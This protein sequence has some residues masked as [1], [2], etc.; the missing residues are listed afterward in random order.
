MNT[1]IIKNKIL[2]DKILKDLAS[3]FENEIYLVGGGVRD[4]ILGKEITD[5][6][7]IVTGM[8]AKDFALKA[9]QIFDGKFIELDEV[10]NIYRVVMKDKINE[11][12]ITN[13]VENSLEKD[14][15]RR[16][17]TINALAVNIKTGEILDLINGLSDIEN[18][19]L[20]GI[21]EENFTDDP[22]RIL[23][24]FRFHSTTGFK[25]SDNLMKIAKKYANLI[26]EPAKERVEYELMKLFD[27]K[28][29]HSALLKMDEAGILEIIFPFVKE[30]KQVPPN[31]HH[32]L[33]LFHHSIETVRQ[34]QLIYENEN[35]FVKKHMNKVDFGGF[36]R[37][38]HLKLA[39]FMH[40]IGKFSTWFI[41]SETGRHRFFKHEDV[42][43]KMCPEI[44]RKLSFSNK[45]INYI[46]LMIKNHM[47]PSMVMSSPELSEKAM[48]RYIRK[49]GDN[50]IDA[51]IIAKADRLS[52]LGPEI[53][54]R[55]VED[56]LNSLTRL[57]D[58]YIKFLDT[59]KPLPKLL[60]GNEVMKLLNISPSPK[61]GKILNA[62]H[63]AQLN[64]D[65]TTKN[66]AVEFVR[67]Y[68]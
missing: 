6:D 24:I 18:G 54:K 42:G 57:C 13:P 64:E 56:N 32:H 15:F 60:D 23:R 62:L 37:L 66:Q 16:D 11:L 58:F 14:I 5:R 61:L 39:G 28:F 47:Y 55:M 34:I 50:S 29:A 12:D 65:V 51:I 63:E 41:E 33:D 17:L 59:I 4:L 30:L 67:K 53:T 68:K 40:D 52:A 8:S 22:L 49:M 1:Q 38:A 7:L 10:N 21:S 35:D 9:A 46:K 36:S 45:Q 2:N 43:A 26:T 44:L 20:N 48:R 25:I 3:R 31:A 27:G 19:I